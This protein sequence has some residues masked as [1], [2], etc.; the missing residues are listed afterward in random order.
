MVLVIDKDQ[1]HISSLKKTV[2][3]LGNFSSRFTGAVRLSRGSFIRRATDQ[4][5]SQGRRQHDE[6]D[7]VEYRFGAGRAWQKREGCGG[8]EYG[9]SQ[10]NP[11][12][13]DLFP[14]VKPNKGQ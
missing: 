3:P 4:P 14:P 11:E 6:E 10:A 2:P 12:N 13:K 7:D 5:W 1:N 8:D 9:S